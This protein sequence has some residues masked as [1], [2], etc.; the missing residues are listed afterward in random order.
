MNYWH[1]ETGHRKRWFFMFLLIPAALVVFTIAV[2][3]LWNAI[4]PDLLHTG[5]L[6]F[7]QALGL[8]ILS[9]LLFG[10]FRWRGEHHA[11]HFEKSQR[12]RERWKG[13]SEEERKEFREKWQSHCSHE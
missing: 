10:G 11:R 1:P 9:R 13:M 7:W 5:N 2:M 4:L 12:F 6:N 8:L 3:L